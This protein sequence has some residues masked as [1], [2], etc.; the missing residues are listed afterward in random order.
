[1]VAQCK[2][3]KECVFLAGFRCKFMHKATDITDLTVEVLAQ[4]QLATERK[5]CVLQ[6][7]L[8]PSLLA[9][10]APNRAL[11]LL[12][13]DLRPSY[14]PLAPF[15]HHVPTFLPL[16]RPRRPPPPSPERLSLLAPMNSPGLM[17]LL[18]ITFQSPHDLQPELQRTQLSP[19]TH[20]QI[21]SSNSSVSA[22]L[23][24]SPAP[25]TS[26]RALS[27]PQSTSGPSGELGAPG[28]DKS[29]I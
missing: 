24:S 28:P 26:P 12:S 10:S 27:N 13:I 22:T 9:V 17:S 29:A 16:Q 21:I 25:P 1:M 14:K 19:S 5:L 20:S 6:H 18:P 2:W 8:A 15:R 7:R 11:K 3:G 23:L 4:R